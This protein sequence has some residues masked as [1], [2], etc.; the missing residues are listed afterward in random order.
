MCIYLRAGN[1]GSYCCGAD[2]TRMSRDFKSIMTWRWPRPNGMKPHE[3][4]VAQEDEWTRWLGDEGKSL[5]SMTVRYS[6]EFADNLIYLDHAP[7]HTHQL[8]GV[9]IAHTVRQ[10]GLITVCDVFF[11]DGLARTTFLVQLQP[12]PAG[13][14][15]LSR[16]IET[17]A[18]AG[19]L[20]AE[21]L[22]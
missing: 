6:D 9:I 1:R 4:I 16:M 17:M 2:D 7:F 14:A 5:V 19:E 18:R 15:T 21:M 20:P 8:V 11:Q 10:R 12:H 13:S 22:A 3:M